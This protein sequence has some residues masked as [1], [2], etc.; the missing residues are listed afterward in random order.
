MM[1]HQA[2]LK[3]SPKHWLLVCTAMTG[4]LAAIPAHAQTTMPTGGAVVAGQATIGASDGG[5]LMIRQGSDKAIIDWAGFSIGAG[6]AVTFDNGTGA[7][8]NR[9]TG[10]SVSSIDGLLSASGSVYLL[11]PNGVIIGEQG[12]V[13]V[14]GSFVASTLDTSNATFLN[15]GDLTLAGSSRASVINLGHIGALGGD[16]VLAAYNVANRGSIASGG[17]AALLAGHE[18]LLADRSVGNGRFGVLIGGAGSSVTQSG[19]IAAVTAEL[20]ANGGSIYALAGNTR[21]I[22][23]ATGVATEAGRIFLTAGTGG[24]IDVAGTDITASGPGA[25][26]WIGSADTGSTTIGDG[27]SIA[28]GAGGFIETSGVRLAVGAARVDPGVGGTWLLDP[29]DL[30]IDAAMATTIETA[31]SG[32]GVK[33]VLTN[34]PGGDQGNITVAAPISWRGDGHLTLDAVNNL[35]VNA[36]ITATGAAAKLTMLYGGA[37][38]LN[39]PITLSGAGAALAINGVDYTLIHDVDQLQAMQNDLAGHYALGNDI[40]ATAT[41]GW[42]GGKGFAPVGSD[43]TQFNGAFT[44]LGHVISSLTINRSTSAYVG[45]FGFAGLGAR[46]RDVGIV[47]VSMLGLKFVGGLAGSSFGTID[48]SYVTGT[49]SGADY[50]IGGLVGQNT[51][52]ITDSFSTAAVSGTHRIGGLVGINT[53]LGVIGGGVINGSYATGTVTGTGYA[54]G[55]LAGINVGTISNS[56]A[57]GAA[58]ATATIAGG[59]VGQNSGTISNSYAT[60]GASTDAGAGGLVGLAVV[61]SIISNSYATG[62]ASAAA[63]NA[64]GLVGQ[65][66]GTISNSYATGGA[67]TDAGAG[68]LVGLAAV[69]SIISNS[70]ATGAASAAA[71]SAGGLVGHNEGTISNSYATGPVTSGT[72]FGG[73]IGLNW[74][75]ANGSYYDIGTTGQSAACGANTGT[76]TATGL[77]T[78]NAFKQASYTGLDFT[79]SWFMVDGSTRPFLRAEWSNT[80]TN[81]HQLQLMAMVL[82]ADYTLGG[83]IDASQTGDFVT[84]PSG[85]W[86]GTGFSPIGDST[87]PFTGSLDGRGHIVADLTINR[88]DQAIVGL[89]GA[90]GAISRITDIG[91]ENIAVTGA[92]NVGG[93]AGTSAATLTG[94]YTTGRVTGANS[95]TT[96]SFNIGGLAGYNNG[97]IS[98]AFSRASVSGSSFI[99]GLVGVNYGPV[100]NAYAT[101]AVTGIPRAGM[102]T[103]NAGGLIGWNYN[104]VTNTYATGAVILT[105]PTTGTAGGLIGNASGGSASTTNS[106]WNINTSGQT[107]SYGGDG[108]TTAEMHTLSTF[109]GWDF[110]MIW[111]PPDATYYPELYGVSG[112]VGVV[113]DD[114]TRVYGDANPDFTG[115]Y[116][117]VGTAPW[118]SLTIDPALA[119]SAGAAS[120]VGSYAITGAGAAASRTGGGASRI[121]YRNGMLTITP[122]HIDVTAV[123]GSSTYGESP[124]NPGLTATNLASFD[125]ISAL[126]G[127]SNGFGISG[128]TGVGDYTLS[129]AGTLGTANYIIDNRIDGAWRVDPRTLTIT[130]SDGTKTYGD[131]LALG[132][133]GFTASGLVNTDT[134]TGTVLTSP[135]AA[136]QASVGTYTVAASGATGNGLA[137]YAIS[138]V[139]GTLAVTARP[140]DVTALGGSSIYG[141]GGANPG[142]SASNL[143]SFDTAAALTGLSNSFGITG[144]TSVGT[145]GLDVIGTLTNPNYVLSTRTSGSWS[146][147][148]RPITVAAN[149]QSRLYGVANPA[150]TYTVT[151][152]NLVNG[153]TLS[154]ALT[155]TA[156]AGSAIGDYAID[157]GT[158]AASAN[159]ALAFTP[160]TLSITPAVL[161]ITAN[162]RTTS[163]GDAIDLG[164]TGFTVSGLAGGDSIAGVTLAS[165]GADGRANVGRYA[166]AVS[167][168]SGIDLSNYVVAYNDGV[169]T[170]TPRAL[171]VAADDRSRVYGDANP[172]LTYAITSGTLVNGDVLSGAMTTTADLQSGVGDYAIDIG[173]LAVSANYALAFTPGT[174]TITPRHIHVIARGGNSV[175]GDGGINPGLSATNLASFDT[176]SA[177]TGLS[178]NFAVTATTDAGDYALAVAGTLTNANYVIDTRSDG[179]WTVMRRALSLAAD[180]ATRVYGDANP[181][182]TYTIT[183]GNLVN[184]DTLSGALATPAELAS[185]VGAYD[186]A[187]GTLAA[188][189]NYALGFTPGTLTITPRHIH[190]T[191]LG[192]SSIYG[193]AAVNPGL[194]A[195]NL[196]SFDDVSVLTGLSSNFAIT[197]TTTVGDYALGVAGNLTNPNYVVDTRIGGS[198]TVTRRAITV[199]AD[200]LA[201]IYGNANPALTYAIGG[202]GLANG[203]TLT[204]TLATAAATQSGIGDYAIDIGTLAASANYAL[205]FVPGVLVI[206]PRPIAITAEDQA[207]RWNTRDPAL[208]Y[209][210]GG[211]GLANGDTLSGGLARA[212]GE[213]PG[214]Y[215]IGQGSLSASANYAVTFTPGT[216]TIEPV[217]IETGLPFERALFAPPEAAPSP[218]PPP[219]PCATEP[220]LTPYPANIDA[221]GT[222][223]FAAVAR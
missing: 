20:R 181:A 84:N 8:L 142:L 62:A 29:I 10:S 119:T 152:G 148:A 166:I 136:A 206:N 208:T 128:A 65:N 165:A 145:Y 188:S 16:V 18:V 107:L 162:D 196:A 66:E 120:D 4:T 134:V 133:T 198:W 199:S 82:A 25:A 75:T 216:L 144:T 5:A 14:G 9:V 26:V 77:S 80:I 151:G 173:T 141:N 78:A 211:E 54:V 122:R 91:L 86:A 175:Y 30:T 126:T 192:G 149:N 73:L 90:L 11:N 52:R 42:N 129:V 176:V 158:L 95:A 164:T 167:G 161:T 201:R 197:G 38:D 154:G 155:T 69:T 200:P 182:L 24:T 36:A 41:A 190:V 115:A 31:L 113:I 17:T 63:Y 59:L 172:A 102:P 87:T 103:S 109:A 153:D 221:G 139:D 121:V 168:A 130:A 207:K 97:T 160:G 50:Y 205:T 110:D 170:V 56:Y 61:T 106:Y 143:A 184:G 114:A 98:G 204:G 44:G 222:I 118:N 146:V 96:S 213:T 74:G 186:I 47:G 189:A 218:P 83:N 101:G 202:L 3:I 210:V 58:S 179:N 194:A 159:Y 2:R 100:S 93:L 104:S 64:G 177:L 132:T 193:N 60:G 169:L 81:A 163:Y 157:I 92:D 33:V 85:M 156:M 183:S 12:V 108:K 185:G 217:L 94:V 215:A 187:Q 195:S 46:L 131:L 15:G 140:I 70:Y 138:Y 23:K 214:D 117:I 191:A 6:G 51:G 22:V 1:R 48:D 39:A 40:D 37:L 19:A 13:D 223:L 71:Y 72:Q 99:G 88:P 180:D 57:T 147:T 21:G 112:V 135:G 174:L 116:T 203:D 150:L 45:L 53:P 127:L 76:C 55:G 7:T 105:G 34:D 89:F 28:T 137:N 32:A 178:N 125:T 123:G 27:V 111:A 35:T 43:V 209:V 68:G 212:A 220:C 124:A 79:N 49:V 67:S 219:Q 171:A